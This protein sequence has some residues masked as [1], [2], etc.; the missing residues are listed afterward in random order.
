MMSPA[1]ALRLV[2][3]AGKGDYFLLPFIGN[4]FITGEVFSL[5]SS[6]LHIRFIFPFMHEGKKLCSKTASSQ[7]YP[8][9]NKSHLP[10][11]LL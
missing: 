9:K 2:T 3:I 11:L 5:T 7:V 10:Q 1:L 4:V 6:W 8:D